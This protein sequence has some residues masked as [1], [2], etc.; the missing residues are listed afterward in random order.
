MTVERSETV[1]LTLDMR[2]DS[3]DSWVV[4][5]IVIRTI[6][7][8]VDVRFCLYGYDAMAHR[9]DTTRTI[10]FQPKLAC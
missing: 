8:I 3:P 4:R 7:L 1:T 2:R 5:L 10:V 9:E 6:R